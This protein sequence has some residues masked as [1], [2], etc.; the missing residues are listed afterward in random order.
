MLSSVRLES[1]DRSLLV[2]D[3][4]L[5]TLINIEY[6]TGITRLQDGD[7]MGKRRQK[8]CRCMPTLFRSAHARCR[9]MRDLGPVTTL[10]AY[11]KK[12]FLFKSFFQIGAIYYSSNDVRF[13]V[14]AT[15]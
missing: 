14:K 3:F 10:S 11:S 13:C 9:S 12:N 7:F 5:N 6:L 2:T 1:T 15:R 4:Q 8:A